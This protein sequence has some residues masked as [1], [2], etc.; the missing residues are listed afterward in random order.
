M[1][2]QVHKQMDGSERDQCNS[3][4]IPKPHKAPVRVRA[5]EQAA[6]GHIHY[7]SPSG[8]IIRMDGPPFPP[9]RVNVI[10]L[11]S[12]P[13]SRQDGNVHVDQCRLSRFRSYL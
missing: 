5:H 4:A 3:S 2:F 8:I 13:L 7:R 9:S 12:S 6:L 11:Y 10:M 1:K